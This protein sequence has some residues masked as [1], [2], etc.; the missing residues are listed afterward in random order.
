MQQPVIQLE[1]VREALA[2]LNKIDNRYRR[3]VTKRIKGAGDEIITQA[4]QMVSSYDNSAA[5][6]APLSGMRR[7]SLVKGRAV[8]WET[9]AVQK[10]F[11]VKV[12]VRA[13]RERYVNFNRSDE[14]GNSYT[15]QVTFGALPYRL[16]VIQQ[17]DG[18]GAIFDHAGRNTRGQ[19]WA[20]LR[21][22]P[23]VGDQP[24]V[25]IP[26]IQANRPGVEDRVKAVLRDVERLTNRNLKL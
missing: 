25:L 15:Q 11:K 10:G 7:G 4:R 5:N 3:G 23:D 14:F 8:R 1:G 12:G 21:A 17:A 16:M 22:Q 20:N 24:R 9:G 26:A 19:F 13:T 6:G 18:A 2:E